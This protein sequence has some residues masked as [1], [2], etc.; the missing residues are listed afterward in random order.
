MKVRKDGLFELEE[1]KLPTGL[2]I[3]IKTRKA[4]EDL[5]EVSYLKLDLRSVNRSESTKR[6]SL[7]IGKPI[8]S[9]SEYVLKLQIQEFRSY[10]I[11]FQPKG[12]DPLIII[13]FEVDDVW[14]TDHP[15]AP[16]GGTLG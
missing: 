13:R 5:Y 8:L 10:G 4:G 9:E 16:A 7:P 14:V 2:D 3:E 6:T 11:V 1:I 12:S 15:L